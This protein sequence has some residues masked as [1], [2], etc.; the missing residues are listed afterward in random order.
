MV[1]K[2]WKPYD[3]LSNRQRRR[4]NKTGICRNE[5]IVALGGDGEITSAIRELG[6]MLELTEQPMQQSIRE[7][8]SE[9]SM[10]NPIDSNVDDFLSLSDAENRYPSSSSEAE[11]TENSLNDVPENF[12]HS[13]NSKVHD[14]KENKEESLFTVLKDWV[15]SEVNVPRVAVSRLLQKVNEIFPSIP[16]DARTLLCSKSE[17]RLK[18]IDDMLYLHIGNWMETI[19]DYITSAIDI[20]EIP[21]R[22][23]SFAINI[24]GLPIYD[25]SPHFHIYPILVRVVEI[26]GKIFV[27]GIFSKEK[28]KHKGLISPDIL[29]KDFIEDLEKL[30]AEPIETKHGNINFVKTGPFICDAPCRAELKQIVSHSGYNSC[31]RCKVKGTYFSHHVCFDSFSEDLRTGENFL[32]RSDPQHHKNLEISLLESSDIDMVSQFIL[33]SM[34]VVYIGVMKRILKRW[35]SSPAGNKRAQLSSRNLE[36]LQTKLEEIAKQLPKEFCR[37]F[38][39]GISKVSYWKATELRTFLLYAAPVILKSK[40]ILP[41]QFYTHLIDLSVAMR[42]LESDGQENNIPFIAELLKKFVSTCVTLY[43]LDFVSYNVHSLTHLVDDYKIFGNLSNVNAFPFE[44]F[45]GSMKSHVRSGYKPLKQLEKFCCMHNEKI[46]LKKS[47]T[48]TKLL[49]NESNINVQCFKTIKIRSFTSNIEIVPSL[50]PSSDNCIILKNGDVAIVKKIFKMQSDDSNSIQMI[51]SRFESLS[52]LFINP[53]SSRKVGIFKLKRLSK[54]EKSVKFSELHSKCLLIS[55]K[56]Y[57]V[58][59]KMLHS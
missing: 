6:D 23:F 15:T 8:N 5:T 48:S 12:D 9:P 43:G 24:D 50:A 46:N 10:G 55:R 34:H 3:H 4:R 57:F 42:L 51:C 11:R 26:P 19:I 31:E 45:L 33:D 18:E 27:A 29:L 37:K 22:T 14:N 28:T 13:Q 44:S 17:N 56:N 53:V 38:E 36:L 30:V 58:G 32:N 41:K 54:S 1:G 35:I 25:N 59:I 20:T 47:E 2:Q 49:K 16:K 7:P 40:D 21:D 52:D 39:Y